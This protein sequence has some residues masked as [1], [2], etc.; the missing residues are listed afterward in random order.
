MVALQQAMVVAVVKTRAAGNQAS[1]ATGSG[2]LPL[3]SGASWFPKV[4]QLLQVRSV[5]ISGG[6]VPQPSTG[7]S[8]W[9]VTSLC[10]QFMRQPLMFRV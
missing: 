10:Q 3:I 6:S 7:D 8:P 9:Q 1:P 4:R 2:G 5:G